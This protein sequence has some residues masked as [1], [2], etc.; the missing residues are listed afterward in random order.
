VIFMLFR[1]Y[2]AIKQTV[3]Q[4]NSLNPSR[5]TRG[6]VGIAQDFAHLGKSRN[7]KE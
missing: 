5:V 2:P 1:S 4:A 6:S 7:S 3:Y